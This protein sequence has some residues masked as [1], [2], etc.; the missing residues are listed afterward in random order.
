MFS[1]DKKGELTFGTCRASISRV[2]LAHVGFDTV[3]PNAMLGAFRNAVRSIQT[4]CVALT[5]H[6][7][8]PIFVD[9]LK[10]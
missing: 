7:N 6:V 9:H 5:T 2:A 3:A 1:N 8:W 10:D 4:S